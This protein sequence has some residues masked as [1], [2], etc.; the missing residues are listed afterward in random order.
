MRMTTAIIAVEDTLSKIVAR[1][2]LA[3]VGL[4]I[5]QTLGLKGKQYLQQ[6]AR[7][8]NQ[9]ARAF[10]VLMLTDLD[11]PGQCPLQL[12]RSW[13]PGAQHPRFFLRVAVMEV[14]S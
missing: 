11:T 5:G 3:A 10:P 12:I 14:E 13:L 7:N 6:R 2:I 8:L 9:T 1:K 4:G